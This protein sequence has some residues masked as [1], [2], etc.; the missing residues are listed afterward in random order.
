MSGDFVAVPCELVKDEHWPDV[1]A[2]PNFCDR[3]KRA[4]QARSGST[5]LIPQSTQHQ[6]PVHQFLWVF[7]P[8]LQCR[9]S[10]TISC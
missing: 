10:S 2:E 5:S 6:V 4:K 9:I 3:Q 8:V 1:E 7:V